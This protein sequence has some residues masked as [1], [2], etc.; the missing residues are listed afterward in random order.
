MV[1]ISRRTTSPWPVAHQR[2]ETGGRSLHHLPLPCGAAD[3][4]CEAGTPGAGAA[5][6][7]TA[8]AL[9]NP[10]QPVSNA[11]FQAHP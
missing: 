7:L 2:Q 6:R 5:L 11:G 10:C 9:G 1:R 4:P 8:E 3:P